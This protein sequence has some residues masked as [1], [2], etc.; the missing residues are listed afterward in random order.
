[1]ASIRFGVVSGTNTKEAAR[2]TVGGLAGCHYDLDVGEVTQGPGTLVGFA[3]LLSPKTG[4]TMAN[5]S[6][7]KQSADATNCVSLNDL[8]NNASRVP[9]LPQNAAPT[10]QP[11]RRSLTGAQFIELIE[12]NYTRIQRNE[13]GLTKKDIAIAMGKPAE[14]SLPEYLMLEEMLKYFDTII[15]LAPAA[16]FRQ[17]RVITP[18]HIEVLGAFLVH[19]E[20]SLAQFDSWMTAKPEFTPPPLMSTASV[21]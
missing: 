15:S 12:K 5:N 8:A 9:P 1:L 4:C 18:T 3:H 21:K 7:Y 13:T 6:Y 16:Y 2:I 10:T 11:V 14:F 19:S 17:A 20:F